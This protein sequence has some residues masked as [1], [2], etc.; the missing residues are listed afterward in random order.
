M[1]WLPD[2]E[3]GLSYAM[4][5]RSLVVRIGGLRGS[6]EASKRGFNTEAQRSQGSQRSKDFWRFAQPHVEAPREAQKTSF[7]TLRS[8][9]L[10]VETL[11]SCLQSRPHANPRQNEVRSPQRNASTRAQPARL[12]VSPHAK[13]L[14]CGAPSC[15]LTLSMSPRTQ[16]SVIRSPS[17]VKN[18]PPAQV[19]AGLSGVSAAIAANRV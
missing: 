2:R 18:A 6:G 16:S 9:R 15:C 7:R 10:C 5:C 12:R 17:V 3:V 4:T 8:L 11:L 14:S 1:T 13:P 19:M